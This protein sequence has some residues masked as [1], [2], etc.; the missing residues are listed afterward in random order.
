MSSTIWQLGWYTTST[1]CFFNIPRII[2]HL[3]VKLAMENNNVLILLGMSKQSQLIHH[4][5]VKKHFIKG[6]TRQVNRNNYKLRFYTRRRGVVGSHD[7]L[8]YPS[9]VPVA[10]PALRY[11]P[12]TTDECPSSPNPP[13]T[14]QRTFATLGLHRLIGI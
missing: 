14:P 6:I 3:G 10:P 11:H 5:T 13:T 9:E 4:G 2:I 12:G 1:F 7:L 8:A